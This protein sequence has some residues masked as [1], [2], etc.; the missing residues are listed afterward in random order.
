MR[1]QAKW[2]S[3]VRSRAV[4]RNQLNRPWFDSTTPTT[5]GPPS[6]ARDDDATT[7]TPKIDDSEETP[8]KQHGE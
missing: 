3:R 2:R 4:Q 7:T 1:Q 5:A 6:A 8:L